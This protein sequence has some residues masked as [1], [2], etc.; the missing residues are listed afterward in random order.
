L[1]I[2]FGLLQHRAAV[3][4]NAEAVEELLAREDGPLVDSCMLVR[5]AFQEVSK[6][7]EMDRDALL[8][9]G[10]DP[11]EE[12]YPPV[13]QFEGGEDDVNEL[14]PIGEPET[15]LD[16]LFQSPLLRAAYVN[17]LDM[18]DTLIRLG[19]DR[20]FVSPCG[21]TAITLALAGC[22]DTEITAK[23]IKATATPANIAP[24]AE[25]RA[26]GADDEERMA[27]W[28]LLIAAISEDCNQNTDVFIA[29]RDAGCPVPPELISD[30]AKGW[31]GEAIVDALRD[32]PVAGL[33]DDLAICSDD[34]G[35]SAM[36][37]DS[38]HSNMD[39]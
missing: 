12:E 19:A 24:P 33:L 37:S 4:G 18:V 28:P 32:P 6:C 39:I 36:E 11:P 38:E 2:E 3:R 13:P 23:I 35:H 21:R 25:V 34:D 16:A 5:A 22:V 10:L 31:L 8:L 7:N 1:A 9:H 27:T 14:F 15:D 20:D 17:N 29:L 26:R 30:E